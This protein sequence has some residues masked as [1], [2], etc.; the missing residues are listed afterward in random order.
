MEFITAALPFLKVIGAFILILVGIR[1]KL[2]LS[3]SILLG[4]AF[5]GLAFG[6]S[7]PAWFQVSGAALIQEKFLFL[8]AIVGLILVFSD[9]LERSGQSTRLMEALSGY[10]VRPK[11]RLIFFPALIGLLPMPGGAVF[12]APMVKAVS[13][14]MK[15]LNED[16]VVINYWFRHVWELGWPLYPGII[17]TVALADIPLSSF[18]SKAWPGVLAMF[19]IGWF[20]FLRSGVLSELTL[21]VVTEIP[22]KNSRDAIREGLPLIIAIAGAVGLEVI[23]AKF[24][25]NIPFEYGVIIA[26]AASV[27][28]IIVQNRLGYGFFS[29]VIKKKSLWSMLMVIAAIFIFKDVMQAAGIVQEMAASVGSGIALFAAAVLLPFLVGMVAG[30]NVAFVGAVFPLLIG[31][32]HSMGMEGDVVP[33]LVLGSFSG[34]TGV[35]ISPIHICFVLTCKYFGVDLA[36][37]WKRL[38][39]PSICFGLSGGLLFW[40]L[41][42]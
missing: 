14:D 39:A 25:P 1:N 20:F 24:V 28:C 21:P 4:G 9:A 11:L 29:E 13:T 27:I 34:F 37:A 32:L 22:K 17:L 7:I 31:L 26:L 5:M 42:V 15:I 19:V 41:I 38:I 6:L 10:L 30:I 33:Y 16:R 18:I 23:I 35:L 2:G 36:R 3:L 8:V 40:F 12:S